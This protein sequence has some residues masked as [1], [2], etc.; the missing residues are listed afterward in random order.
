MRAKLINEKF[1]KESDPI[2]DMKIGMINVNDIY[3]ETIEAAEKKYNDFMRSFLFKKICLETTT[4]TGLVHTNT[5]IV[6]NIGIRWSPNYQF[7]D[8]HGN[9]FEVNRSSKIMIIK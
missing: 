9:E 4:I 8:D 2:H 3:K 7:Y 6:K 1:T 5:F